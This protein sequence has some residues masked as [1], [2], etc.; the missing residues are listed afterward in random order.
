VAP[1]IT[2]AQGSA[3]LAWPRGGHATSCVV[4]GTRIVRLSTTLLGG[5]LG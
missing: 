4:S 2:M 1:K 5:V 3:G